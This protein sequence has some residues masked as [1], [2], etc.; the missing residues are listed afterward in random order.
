MLCS[1]K[2]LEGTNARELAHMVKESEHPGLVEK[3]DNELS[4]KNKRE[5]KRF[6][7]V[8]LTEEDW[9][10]KNADTTIRNIFS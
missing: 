9:D 10:D 2:E 4:E 8:C 5:L 7:L 1:F 3:N 6:V